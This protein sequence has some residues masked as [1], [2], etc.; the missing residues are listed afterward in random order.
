MVDEAHRLKNDEAALYKELIQWSFKSKLLVTG[1]PL[2]VRGG[3]GRGACLPACLLGRLRAP[4][5]WPAVL[6][7]RPPAPLHTCPAATAPLPPIARQNNI[8]ELW[9][10]LHF[11]HPERFTD[12]EDFEAEY[13]VHDP[14]SVRPLTRCVLSVLLSADL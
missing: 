14:E 1:T 7:R 3:F 5:L 10:L 4:V 13:D 12:S 11:L 6:A 2:Q 9:A 8:R